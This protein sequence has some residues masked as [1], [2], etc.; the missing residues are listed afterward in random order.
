MIYCEWCHK[1]AY[2]WYDPV[3]NGKKV[4]LCSRCKR[5]HEKAEEERERIREWNALS[6]QPLAP[7]QGKKQES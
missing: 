6:T 2:M 3:I 4:N 1:S 7:L 5:K